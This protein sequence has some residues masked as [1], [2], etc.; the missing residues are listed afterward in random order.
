MKSYFLRVTKL[1]VQLEFPSLP[2]VFDISSV[3]LFNTWANLRQGHSEYSLTI[4]LTLW[5]NNVVWRKHGSV[6]WPEM[7]SHCI[8]SSLLAWNQEPQ[9][10]VWVI[11]MRLEGFRI[12]FFRSRVSPINFN[13]ACGKSRSG[14]SQNRRQVKGWIKRNIMWTACYEPGLSSATVVNGIVMKTMVR[15]P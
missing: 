11:S 10:H 1:K 8:S 14:D 3:P 5:S 13:F 9:S 6:A 2:V 7:V 15:F 12:I 4:Y